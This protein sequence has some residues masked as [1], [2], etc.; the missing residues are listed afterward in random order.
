MIGIILGPPGSGKGTQAE[1]I[2][3]GLDLEHLS[4][5]EILRAE[6]E[7]RSPLGEHA[8]QAMKGGELVPDEVM[9]KL[10]ASRLKQVAAGGGFLLDGFPR[11][12]DQAVA[13]DGILAASG[14]RVDFVIALEAD[15]ADLTSR[16]LK[17]AEIEGRKDDTRKAIQERMLEYREHTAPVLGHYQACGGSVEVLDAKGSVS[18]V[19]Q[20][21]DA[22]LDR[23]GAD[24]G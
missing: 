22:A 18:E 2:G 11:T 12:V 21:V 13:L 5:G 4:T 1:R 6:V 15:E 10:V 23:F 19:S 16:L 14:S 3:A 8:A 9:V 7:R 17:R 20:L 24:P